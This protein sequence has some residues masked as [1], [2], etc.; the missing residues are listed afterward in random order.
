[1][2]AALGVAPPA[3]AAAGTWRSPQTLSTGRA[4]GTPTLGFD[5]HGGA[6]ATWA[7]ASRA[8]RRSASRLPL[9]AAFRPD[10]AAR[11]IG[12]E[13]V[14]GPPPRRSSTVLAA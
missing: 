8:G 7:T 10:R 11:N 6:L 9:E 1:V 14:E 2:A 4:A 3:G 13:V 5:A 12:E